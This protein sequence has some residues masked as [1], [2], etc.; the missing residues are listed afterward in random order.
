[1]AY[2]RQGVHFKI[3]TMK[4]TLTIEC[5]SIQEV[6]SALNSEHVAKLPMPVSIS[7]PEI[8]SGD[9]TRR[10]P[11]GKGTSAVCPACGST[12]TRKKAGQ[13]FCCN[14]CKG[15]SNAIKANAAR[16]IRESKTKKVLEGVCELCSTTF[17]KRTKKQRFCSQLCANKATA[18]NGTRIKSK[19]LFE[20]TKQSELPAEPVEIN[21]ESRDVFI[22]G[23]ELKY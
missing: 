13:K 15:R 7:M 16:K 5:E 10:L 21:K 11:D 19:K 9:G 17:K 1:M 14:S 4:I 3:T 20:L 23:H 18:I 6:L 12:F 8:K 22:V 2:G